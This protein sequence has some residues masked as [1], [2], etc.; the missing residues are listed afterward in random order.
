MATG[1][2]ILKKITSEAKRIRSNNPSMK[3]TDAVKK[4]S[5]FYKDVTGKT[6]KAVRTTKN[7]AKAVKKG[8]A[9]AKRSYKKSSKIGGFTFSKFDD[10]AKKRNYKYKFSDLDKFLEFIILNEKALFGK[11]ISNLDWFTILYDY[12]ALI[13]VM[14]YAKLDTD[15][16]E[17]E[18]TAPKYWKKI[19]TKVNK[20]I[21]SQKKALSQYQKDYASGKFGT[22]K[23][24][25]GMKKTVTRN[26]IGARNYDVDT[27]LVEDIKLYMENDPVIMRNYEQSFLTNIATKA[28]RGNLDR[29]KIPKLMEY[30]YKNHQKR[31]EKEYGYSAKLNPAERKYLA[32]LWT[33][34]AIEDLSGNYDKLYS[35]RTGKYEP[36]NYFTKGNIIGRNR[37]GIGMTTKKANKKPTVKQVLKTNKPVYKAPK[38]KKPTL[39]TLK[40][41]NSKLFDD[42]YAIP[43]V[44][45]KIFYSPYLGQ[46]IL[47]RKRDQNKIKYYSG[48]MNTTPFGT[49]D[50]YAITYNLKLNYMDLYNT[51]QDVNK[52]FLTNIKD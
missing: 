42:Y 52:K 15:P 6:K 39:K 25:T 21:A 49:Y 51:I 14:S 2:N 48:L 29:N 36:L 34:Q 13:D 12:P 27:I 38:P 24:K 10:L 37:G 47:I 4:A 30:L 19:V 7:V 1:S 45:Q 35:G 8:Y 31:I 17:D 46:W 22:T 3:W 16:L 28:G 43:Y 23:T 26:K 5:L 11:K 41:V 44:E 20:Q 18:E 32:D 50:V 9:S 33:N 40:E